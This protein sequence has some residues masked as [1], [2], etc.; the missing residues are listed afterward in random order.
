MGRRVGVLGSDGSKG[1]VVKQGFVRSE[2][3]QLGFDIDI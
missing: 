3:V 2:A 1:E